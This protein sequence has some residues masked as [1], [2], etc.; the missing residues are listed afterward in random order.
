[1][2]RKRLTPLHRFPLTISQ[3]IGRY[4]ADWWQRDTRNIVKENGSTHCL[5]QTIF[6]PHST[7]NKSRRHAAK[8]YK[9]VMAY[10][11]SCRRGIIW[12]TEQQVIILL[13]LLLRKLQLH[14]LK[15]HAV[16][17]HVKLEHHPYQ[18]RVHPQD[19]W[20]PGHFNSGV[21]TP[22]AIISHCLLLWGATI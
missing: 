20:G 4:R 13:L 22:D 3:F 2:T 5:F 17:D 15:V 12:T 11:C 6:A 14:A 8:S 1:M 10:I 18:S 21:S 19:Q 9:K 7:L 16:M